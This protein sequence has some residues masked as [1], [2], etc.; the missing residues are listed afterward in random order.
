MIDLFAAVDATDDPEATS[1]YVARTKGPPRDDP[2]KISN[3]IS[4]KVRR[5]MVDEEWLEKE[6]NLKYDTERRIIDS[7]KA[8]GDDEDPETLIAMREKVKVEKKAIQEGNKRK[9][10][11]EIKKPRKKKTQ[12][13]SK[14]KGK[15]RAVDIRGSDG[16]QTDSD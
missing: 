4:N 8:W 12:G 2:P 11:S 14:G 10:R 13:A 15:A 9:A 1:K 7:G 3:K 5:W 16:S 6:E